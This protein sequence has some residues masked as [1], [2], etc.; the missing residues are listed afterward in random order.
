[1]QALLWLLCTRIEIDIFVGG[2]ATVGS[3]QSIAGREPRFHVANVCKNALSL[4]A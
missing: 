2:I 4:S 3:H 1:M